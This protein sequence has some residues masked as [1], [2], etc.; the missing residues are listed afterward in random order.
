MTLEE[1][2]SRIFTECLNTPFQVEVP[3]GEPLTLELF[4]VEEKNYGPQFE[5]FS[6]MFRGGP[7]NAHLSQAI[8]ALEHAKLGRIELFLVPVGPDAKGMR[9]EAVFNRRRRDQG[10]AA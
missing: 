7:A 3:G 1:L 4:A 10:P 6:V 5:Q 8:Y 9:Y 2:N